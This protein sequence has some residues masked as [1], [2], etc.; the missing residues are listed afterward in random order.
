MLIALSEQHL[1]GGPSWAPRGPH[2][3]P[4]SAPAVAGLVCAANPVAPGGT[5]QWGWQ[6][7]G[8][9]GERERYF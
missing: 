9:S 6:A 4:G 7:E 1:D 8:F 2:A 3:S 5:T